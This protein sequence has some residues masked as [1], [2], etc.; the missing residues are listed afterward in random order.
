MRDDPERR[1]LELLSIGSWKLDQDNE[2]LRQQDFR[3]KDV[4]IRRMCF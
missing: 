2:S 1:L 3:H 4:C